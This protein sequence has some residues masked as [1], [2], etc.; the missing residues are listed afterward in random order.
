MWKKIPKAVRVK[1]LPNFSDNEILS[2]KDGEQETFLFS[3]GYKYK[4]NQMLI[5]YKNLIKVTK[6]IRLE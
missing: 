2:I 6:Y 5:L 1:M 3:A 4:D